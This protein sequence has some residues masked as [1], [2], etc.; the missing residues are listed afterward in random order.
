MDNM[1]Q[2]GSDPRV[3][4]AEVLWFWAALFDG[5]PPDTAWDAMKVQVWPEITKVSEPTATL[6]RPSLDQISQEQLTRE[7][8]A[9]FSMPV[10]GS[11]F[12]LYDEE[13]D[14]YRD[15]P[16]NLRILAAVVELPWKK[17]EFIPGRAYP[18]SPDHLSV[19]L[20]LWAV[21]L[22]ADEGGMLGVSRDKWLEILGEKIQRILT[23]LVSTL[24]NASG[25]R[26]IAWTAQQYVEQVR[27]WTATDDTER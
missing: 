22:S 17:T 1:P 6:A 7:Y 10:S 25:Y 24:P 21:M 20:A 26:A 11:P 9:W 15:D 19:L 12:S 3:A 23:R 27:Q 13:P 18:V 2:D 4:I 16:Q 14:A 8:Q 5:P